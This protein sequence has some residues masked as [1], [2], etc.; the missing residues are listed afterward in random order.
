MGLADQLQQL[1]G[2]GDFEA[3]PVVEGL[4]QA[5]GGFAEIL[6]ADHAAAALEG[7]EAAPD[8]GEH[9]DVVGVP[10][11]LGEALGDGVADV[12][13][14]FEEDRQQLG[15]EFFF[16]GLE[17]AR[18]FGGEGRGGGGLGQ[19]GGFGEEFASVEEREGLAGLLL[20][21]EVGGERGVLAQAFEVELELGAQADVLGVV[22]E[23]GGEGGGFA[24]LVGE[25]GLDAIG[26]RRLAGVRV[27]DALE[28]GGA[29]LQGVNVH[30]E[31]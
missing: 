29:V 14:F 16:A 25:F 24:L 8:G 12:L 19:L 10:D 15:V 20:E 9:L 30:A 11:Q 22:L 21:L 3:Q 13:G 28:V 31:G 27:Q 18:G 2:D 6:E 26:G 23:G 7:V 1:V 4:L 17:E 5:P